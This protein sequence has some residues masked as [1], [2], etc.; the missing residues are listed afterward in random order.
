ME[1]KLSSDRSAAVC[2]QAVLKNYGKWTAG[3]GVS[4]LGKGNK[5]QFGLQV[6]VNLW[7]EFK[8]YEYLL[9]T[10]YIDIVILCFVDL[11]L[12]DIC[13]VSTIKK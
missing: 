10:I 6:D 9:N 5:S 2:Y 7:F 1:F 11:I 8:L 13:S 4:D 3:W 12:I